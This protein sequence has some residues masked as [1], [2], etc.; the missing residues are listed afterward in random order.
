M[1]NQLVRPSCIS[2]LQMQFSRLKERQDRK[3]AEQSFTSIDRRL[4]DGLVDPPKQKK[5]VQSAPKRPEDAGKL[6]R[7]EFM[8]AFRHQIEFTKSEKPL[9][10]SAMVDFNK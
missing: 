4:R 9:D 8:G 7:S 2:T 3:R 5:S 10:C 6:L 1:T